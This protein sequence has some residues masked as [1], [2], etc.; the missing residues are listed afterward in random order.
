MDEYQSLKRELEEL[1]SRHEKTMESL[2]V[3][4]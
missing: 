4:L 1:Q 3:Q 2:T